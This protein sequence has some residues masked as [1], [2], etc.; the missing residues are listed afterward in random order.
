M[1][2]PSLVDATEVA[3]LA[4]ACSLK[5]V[6]AIRFTARLVSD[7]P[8]PGSDIQLN[9]Q[10]R[11][12]FQR[13]QDGKFAVRATFTLAAQVQDADFTRMTYDVVASYFA[14]SEFSDDTLL[15][16]AQTNSMIH[17]WPYFRA[18]VQRSCGELGIA[19]MTIPVFRIKAATKPQS[20][21]HAAPGR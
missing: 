16:F 13:G 7:A 8:E 10:P 15:A 17:L 1:S 5:D 6:R 19:P 21:P 3:K 20:E 4:A 18:F 11:V 12:A 14:Q 2:S 9:I